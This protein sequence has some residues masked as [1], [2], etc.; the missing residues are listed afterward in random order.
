MKFSLKTEVKLQS[1]RIHKV[2]IFVVGSFIKFSDTRKLPAQGKPWF[3]PLF[4]LFSVL[5][6][7]A[8]FF[9]Y[10]RRGLN[11]LAIHLG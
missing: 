2:A 9:L 4:Y 6:I 1:L 7:Y 8:D 5:F 3:F 11:W 10:F